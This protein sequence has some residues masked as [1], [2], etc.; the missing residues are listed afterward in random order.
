[1]TAEADP[2]ASI[3]SAADF[4]DTFPDGVESHYWTQARLRTV[5]SALKCHG[6]LSSSV[7]DF[8]AGRGTMVGLLRERGIDAWGIEPGPAVIAPKLRQ[9]VAANTEAKSLPASERARFSDILLLDVLEHVERPEQLL[10]EVRESFPNV[11]RLLVTLPARS[12]LWSNYDERFGHFRRYDLESAR[13]LLESLPGIRV[14]MCR[15]F[16]RALYPAIWLVARK[17]G[18]RS[19][20]V[21]PPRVPVAHRALAELLVLSDRVLPPRWYGSSLIAVA[22]VN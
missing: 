7:L 1:M 16:F 19:M 12:E 3:F 22:S 11:R 14:Q 9:Y 6:A 4:A 8:G 17:P 10:R 18:G 20:V 2:K 21:R 13:N 5:L 15:Y